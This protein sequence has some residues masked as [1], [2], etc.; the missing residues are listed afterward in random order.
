MTLSL[1]AV[2]RQKDFYVFIMYHQ[3]DFG[4][5]IISVARMGYFFANWTTLDID[6]RLASSSWHLNKNWLLGKT[7]FEETCLHV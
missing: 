7:T 3:Q 2:S 1:V 4:E 5:L 6:W